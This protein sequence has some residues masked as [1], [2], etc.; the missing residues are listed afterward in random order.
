MSVSDSRII[1]QLRGGGDA[2]LSRFFMM[3]R[4]TL[5][6]L[7]QSRM[8]PEL[9][10]RLDGSDIVQ[11]AF[12]LAKQRVPTYVSNPTSPFF[13]WLRGI[14][15][16]TLSLNANKHINTQRRSIHREAV[17]FS[18]AKKSDPLLQIAH[19]KEGVITGSQIDEVRSKVVDMIK[20]M[21][22]ADREILLLK[23]VHEKSLKQ[24]AVELQISYEAV[25]KRY[26][27]ALQ[28]LGRLA[29]SLK[30]E[31]EQQ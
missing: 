3:Y 25:R 28:R 15:L 18:T 6:Q 12:I 31:M 11:E 8:S 27:R 14:C 29:K 5:R 17:S 1:E 30:K 16:E 22:S 9:L 7:V 20:T 4:Q 21:K 13:D 24:A 19:R 26:R 2:A 23:H 10:P